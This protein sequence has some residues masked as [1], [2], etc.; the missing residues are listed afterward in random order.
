MAKLLPLLS[1]VLARLYDPQMADGQFADLDIAE[2]RFADYQKPDG[3]SPER[4]RADCKR[5][6]GQSG[7]GQTV[8]QLHSSHGRA[9]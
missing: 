6:K 8:R 5:A 1:T 4:N 3:D 9:S 7:D 2:P